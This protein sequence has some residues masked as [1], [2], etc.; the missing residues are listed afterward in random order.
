ML[1][2]PA[3]WPRD[4]FWVTPRL[5]RSSLTSDLETGSQVDAPRDAGRS[6]V[7]ART[8]GLSVSMLRMGD[9]TSMVCNFYLSVAPRITV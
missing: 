2:T 1:S 7:S 3:L 8:A 5:S 9:T 4:L 6:G